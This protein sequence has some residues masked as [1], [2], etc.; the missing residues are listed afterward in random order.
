MDSYAFAKNDHVN[1]F[2]PDGRNPAV[3]WLRPIVAKGGR[4]GMVSLPGRNVSRPG[5]FLQLLDSPL[6]P[7]LAHVQENRSK[8]EILQEPPKL[9]QEERQDVR[10]RLA[11][12]DQDNWLH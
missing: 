4:I 2:D 7:V 1:L 12:L 11:E 10:M 8:T 3:I 6:Q 9:T 5:A